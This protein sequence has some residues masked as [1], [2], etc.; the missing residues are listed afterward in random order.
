MH[1]LIIIGAGPAG[2]SAAIY[3][4]RKKMNLLVLADDD[5]GQTAEAHQ[6]ENYLG[7]PSISGNELNDKF[8]EHAKILGIEIGD[9][10]DVEKITGNGNSF[11]ITA[12]GKSY[13]AKCLIVA[14]GKKYRELDVP[15]AKEFKGKGITYC[16]TCD[17]PMFKNKAVAV[18]GAGDA[19]QDAAW[20]LI[21]Y[22]N[23]IYL[24]NKYPE[25]RG[26]NRQMQ[27]QL[28]THP[29]VE[30]F[31]N[32]EPMEIKGEGFVESLTIKCNGNG[33]EQEIPVNGIFVEIG[34]VPASKFLAGMV[35]LNDK[36]EIVV[37]PKTNMSSRP[38]IFAAGDVTNVPHK[39]MIIAAGEGAKA[40]LSVYEYLKQSK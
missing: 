23:K 10:N 15:G 40:A 9:G 36:E 28:K 20:Q 5:R 6:V 18:V 2:L 21:K 12:G 38:G 7:I 8:R 31:N 13:S 29:Q 14:T 24:L 34:S 4:A 26:D 33:R 11:E 39:Q 25:L 1:D 35:E 19:G 37:D 32:C 3:A 17:A 16:A 30:I 22:A 27:E